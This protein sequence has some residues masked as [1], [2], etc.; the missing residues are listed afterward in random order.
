VSK[1]VK[2]EEEETDELLKPW[3]ARVYW[4]RE[5]PSKSIRVTKCSSNALHLFPVLWSIG[6]W[7]AA[8]SADALSCGGGESDILRRFA[9]KVLWDGPAT[10]G[11]GGGLG[12]GGVSA[13][14]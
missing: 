11:A 12:A 7:M 3:L 2:E 4:F 1:P 9:G 13:F 8:C 10:G 14:G 6:M 5:N